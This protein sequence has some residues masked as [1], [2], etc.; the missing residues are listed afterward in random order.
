MSPS[1]DD[2]IAWLHAHPREDRYEL[3]ELATYFSVAPEHLR[4]R[5]RRLV[6]QGMLTQ[7]APVAGLADANPSYQ[8]AIG[9][10][11]HSLQ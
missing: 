3:Y 9:T 11:D 4:D 2:I 10:E 1:P 5:L 7:S 8:V 6:E